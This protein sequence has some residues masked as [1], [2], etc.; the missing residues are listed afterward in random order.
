MTH[1]P[2]EQPP[3]AR[4]LLDTNV[5]IH[6]AGLEPAQLPMET[7][8]SAITLAE[9]SAAVHAGISDADRA[10]RIGLLQRVEAGFDPLP[11]D[12]SAA[13]VY[14]R[15]AAAVRAA[16]RSPRSRV[17]DQMIAA[18]AAA[19]ALPLYTTNASDYAGLD[20]IVTVVEVR[21][22]PL[23]PCSG[24]HSTPLHRRA[25]AHRTAR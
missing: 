11:F 4:G 19:H 5:V 14:G 1:S 25:R 17:A 23:N 20:E 13:R 8:V 18:V 16:G 12:V 9:L 2:G 10:I 24:P 3:A 7:A 21:Q 22:P 15:I 6:W